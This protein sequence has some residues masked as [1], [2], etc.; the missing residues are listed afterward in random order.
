MFGE[1]PLDDLIPLVL[2]P[3]TLS[4]RDQAQ[5]IRR[6][7]E[8]WRDDLEARGMA[9]RSEN[10]NVGRA[11]DLQ[12]PKFAREFLRADACAARAVEGTACG[13]IGGTAHQIHQPGD[14]R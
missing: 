11:Q 14:R 8:F 10:W 1:C 12:D 5:D 2:D 4:K 3:R 7:Q 6:A 9:R 13:L